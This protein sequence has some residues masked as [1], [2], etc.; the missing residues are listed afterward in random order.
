M[1]PRVEVLW[2]LRDP[3]RCPTVIVAGVR[4]LLQKLGPGATESNRS[5]C[6][7]APSRPRRPLAPARDVRLPARG[8]RRAPRRVRPAR[9]DRRRVPSTADA[10]IRIDLWGDEV[11]RLT[12]LQRE[13]PALDRRP[14]RGVHLP[15]ARAGARRRGARPGRRPGRHRTVG[16]RAVGAPRRR[17][18]LRRHG[19][20]AAVAR[21]VRPPPHRRAA[22]NAKVCSSS[23]AGCATAPPTCSP[24]RT[25]SP[26][27]SPPPGPATPTS[28]SPVSTPT[29]TAARHPA[30]Q[31]P[32]RRGLLVD[33]LTPESPTPAVVEA[34]GWGPVAGDGT[35]LTDRL[36]ELLG[37][38]LAGG[39]G[40][41]R[42]RI[43]PPPA[44]LLLD[45]GLDFPVVD[46][47]VPDLTRPAGRRH[48]RAAAPRLLAAQRQGRDHRRGDLTGRRRAHRT[49]PANVRRG[50]FEDLKP[51]TTWCTT[52]TASASTRAWS[53]APSAASSATTC[54][55]PTRAATSCTCRPTR[56]TP[57]AS[58]S[59]AR[60]HAAPA[61]RIRLREGQVARSARPCA[62]SPRNSSCSTRSGSTP[63]GPRVR[64]RH[65]LAARDGGV[66]PVRRDARPTHGDRR[67]Q[68]RHGAPHPMDRLLCG[69][70]GFGKTEV[71]IRAAFKA[72]QDGKQ[73]AVLAPPRCSPRST[74]TRS[75]TGSPGTRS[76]SRC[77]AASSPTARRRR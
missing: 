1:G 13:R 25:T 6:D 27:P 32:G 69:D 9:R 3:D 72:I 39:G 57:C 36:T 59:A 10:P 20:L 31:R 58:T 12:T 8:A 55:S 71:A 62:R 42:H 61:R 46:P 37:R 34:S 60:P 26:G 18:P 66:V 19:E 52:S 41:R 2:R 76:G 23:R 77:S 49:P 73:V 21:R 43:G 40:R 74:A 56:S 47:A 51:A 33:R 45:H 67:R 53:S 68:G 70:V 75:P 11:D 7:P 35:G 64:P 4:A 48:R 24:R 30:R 5:S 14:R 50:F 15:G 16:S 29:P 44:D 54:C 28:R 65:A 17:R 22:P 38:R 63:T